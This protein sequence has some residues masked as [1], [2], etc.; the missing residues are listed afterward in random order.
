[1]AQLITGIQQIGIGI[2]D[3]HAAKRWYRDHF[4]MTA[5]VFS[6]EAEAKLMTIYTG[7]IVQSRHAVLSLNMHGGGGMEIWQYTSK[8]PVKP[9]QK[10]V[11]GD[12]GI[13]AAKLK[14]SNVQKLYSEHTPDKSALNDYI[15]GSQH[16]WITDPWDNKFN[17]V[18]GHDWFAE[19]GSSTGGI[20]GAVIGVSDIDKALKLYSDVLG[21]SEIVA[22]QTGVFNDIP[23]ASVA[24]QKYRR[25]IIR[26]KM[27]AEGAFSK[28]LGGVELELVQALDRKP[29]KIFEGRH[30]GDA[31]FIHLC[32]DV[33]D[34]KTLQHKCEQNGFP[35][36][37]D[38]GD[39]FDMG[40]SGGRFSYC[41]DPDGTWIEMVETHKVPILK[42][43]G[44]YLNL[45]KRGTE[46]TLPDWMVKMLGMTKVK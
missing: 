21:I 27:K 10:P 41:E 40:D 14:S 31:G 23:D 38:S 33:L 1:M 16:Y 17:I 9:A 2:P 8:V 35:F 26:K 29:T 6:D 25:V 37:V 28:L 39:T 45:K 43:F 18:P 42:K 19:N 34:M 7:G 36:T 20:Y 12:L 4:G 3:V 46:R 22:D 32:F 44:W 13:Y 15:G 11:F 24:T 5:Q 30:W